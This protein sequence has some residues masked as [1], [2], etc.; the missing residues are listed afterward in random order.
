VGSIA[1]A[2]DYRD[3][4]RQQSRASAGKEFGQECHNRLGSVETD[5]HWDHLIKVSKFDG[6]IPCQIDSP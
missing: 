3:Q 2:L 5:R 4:S 1:A 6:E